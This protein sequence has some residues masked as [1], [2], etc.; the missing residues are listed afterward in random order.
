MRMV[1]ISRQLTFVMSILTNV[2]L[3][4]LDLNLLLVL[5][6]VLAEQS[7]VGAARRLHVTPPAISN[8]LARLR[9]ALGDPIVTRSGR[10]IVPTPRAQRLGPA[11]RRAL[12]E[13]DDALH[14]DTFDPTTSA[15]QITLAIA[16]AGQLARLPKLT[17]LL[18]TAM[19]RARLRVIHVDAM[20]ALG[21]IAGTEVDVAIG[22]SDSAPGIRRK[23][24]YDE[25]SVVI[26]RRAH[27]RIGERVTKSEL[28]FERHV[29]VHV[30]LGRA[31]KPVAQ[32]YARLGVERN[33]AMIVPA[34]AAAVA[35]VGAT[36]L[37]ATIPESVVRVL[38][39]S[40]GVRA[41]SSPL[42]IAPLP[43]HMSWHD[44][45]DTD[46]AMMLFRDLVVGAMS[47]TS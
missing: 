37:I 45:T 9:A 10:G 4:A 14:G 30:A 17:K 43:M 47:A 25:R 7:V 15:A 19:P 35:A 11:I 2:N 42:K 34:F 29:E 18:A 8:A 16:D 46:P 22:V 32:A 12:G 6:A 23:K 26:S 27:P 36:D 40:L 31:S 1:R 39:S 3:S 41:V 21:G 13:I 44:R 5:D 33:V 28:A 20:I 38:G 24:L